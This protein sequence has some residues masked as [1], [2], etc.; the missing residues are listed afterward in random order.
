M[1]EVKF[2]IVVLGVLCAGACSRAGVHAASE[3]GSLTGTVTSTAEGPMEGVLVSA[4]AVGGTITVTVV[5]DEHGSY[6]FPK[7]RLNS[8]KYRLGIRAA[9]YVL[10]DSGTIDV[11]ANGPTRV[12]L[13]LQKTRDLAPQLM[14]AEWLLSIQGTPEQKTGLD[15]RLDMFDKDRCSFC[16]S[17]WLVTRNGHDARE[18]VGVLE[19]MRFHNPGASPT[20]PTDLPYSPRF[21]QYWGGL[22]GREEGYDGEGSRQVPPK[23]L[24]QAAYL[25]SINLSTSPDGKWKYPLRTL[26]R[27]KGDETSVVITQYDLPRE[28]CQPHD[29]A[30][31]QEGM[32]WYQDFGQ[33]FIG[34]LNPRTGQVKEWTLPALK[35]YPPFAEGGLDVKID[36]EGNPWFAI[37]RGAALLRFDK[38]TE[39]MTVWSAPGPHDLG[40]TIAQIAISPFVDTGWVWFRGEK[41]FGL[42]L[43]T[44][45]IAKTYD[46]PGGAYGIEA[47]ADG[48]VI[49][50]SMGKGIV[51]ELDTKTG[52]STLYPT[53]TPNSGP[54]RGDVDAQDRAWFAEYYAGKFG[55]LDR[56]T[57]EIKEWPIPVPYADPYDVVV[58]R[59]GEVWSGGMV[60]DYIFRLDPATGRITK[61]LL[62]T[63]DTN[64]RRIDVDNSTTPVGVWVGETHHGKIARLEVLQGR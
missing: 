3:A 2:I 22:P 58:A 50:F 6:A 42:D 21:K 47:T 25:A 57:K 40:T 29:A 12:D 11:T 16:H 5:S 26:P 44:N 48:N 49:F 13:K 33:G 20:H 46:I 38:K 45:T 52:K 8:G 30:V 61:Y 1:R 19:R 54:R 23:V 39:K 15:V 17:F 53:P 56:K 55:M 31:D 32:V 60:T 18:W 34:R 41:F 7:G 28:D 63:V 59:N 24:E 64:V 9:G 43:K 51:G 35:P 4:K 36:R 10:E 27:P 62:P 37:Q 14:N